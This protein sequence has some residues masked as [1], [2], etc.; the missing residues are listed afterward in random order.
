LISSANQWAKIS[1]IFIL[2]RPLELPVKD[3]LE[4]TDN[5]SINIDRRAKHLVNLVNLSD[6]VAN[7]VL[8]L[9]SLEAR[10]T[11]YQSKIK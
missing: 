11:L 8:S 1:L 5:C 6:F 9:A 10:R 4:N 3:F 7:Q 2:G